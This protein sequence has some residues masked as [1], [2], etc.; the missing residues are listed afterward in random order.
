MVGEGVQRSRSAMQNS[1][2]GL[3]PGPA[4]C[5]HH[6]WGFQLM[7]TGDPKGPFCWFVNTGWKEAELILTRWRW[8][9]GGN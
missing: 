3:P 9:E 2:A 4:L 5:V 6:C 8:W 7:L 1:Q